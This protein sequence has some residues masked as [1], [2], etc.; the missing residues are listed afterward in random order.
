MEIGKIY[1]KNIKITDNKIKLFKKIT[2]DKNPIHQNQNLT[3]QFSFKDPISN[4]FLA[5]SLLSNII[6]IEQPIPDAL[7]TDYNLTFSNTF[8]HKIL[9]EIIPFILPT[10]VIIFTSGYLNE[11]LHIN[12]A[13]LFLEFFIIF[14][15]CFIASKKPPCFFAN[16]AEYTPGL[17]PSDFIQ[18]PESSEMT[19]NLVNLET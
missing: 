1:K 11:R 3:K 17:C 8:F 9:F 10:T 7:C 15:I 4:E 6:W 16:L 14:N 12:F 18:S 19:V 13:D 2:L 5:G